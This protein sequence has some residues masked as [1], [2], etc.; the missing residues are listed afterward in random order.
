MVF[1]FSAIVGQEPMKRALLACMV[2]PALHGVL[3]RGERGTAKSTAVRALVELLP[4]Q[5]V[6]VGCP[7]GCDPDDEAGL[8]EEC[9]ARGRLQAATRTMPLVDLPVGATEDRVLGTVDVERALRDGVEAFRPGLLASVNRGILYIDEVNLLGDHLMDVLLDAAAMGVNVVEREGISHAHPSRFILVGTMNP[10]EGNLRPQLTDRFDLGVQVGGLATPGERRLVLERRLAYEQDPAGF[11][12]RWRERE[13]RVAERVTGA[14]R[15]IARVTVPDAVLDDACALAAEL[16]LDGHRAEIAT[17]KA[18]RAL[19]ALDGRR[20][21]DREV[22]TEAARLAV[23]HRLR[24]SPLGDDVTDRA[25]LEGALERMAERERGEDRAG[26]G[27]A[28]KKRAGRTA[29]R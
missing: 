9:R 28:K 23:A 4:E 12:D 21:V 15:D 2:D 18:A 16:E 11:A 24:R 5:R 10:E 26:A 3:V 22:F 19:A 6:V 27:G 29:T 25:Q 8:C 13:R 7:V 20:S 14:A 1:P 17:V